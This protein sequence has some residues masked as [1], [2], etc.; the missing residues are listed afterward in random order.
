MSTSVK[1]RVPAPAHAL[2]PFSPPRLPLISTDPSGAL[3]R[4]RTP[5][6]VPSQVVEIRWWAKP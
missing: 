1:S 4:R 2:A 3:N 6:E 5:L